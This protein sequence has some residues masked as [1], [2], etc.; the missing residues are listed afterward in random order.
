MGDRRA[1]TAI[2]AVE[3]LR[4]AGLPFMGTLVPLPH[5]S[6][7]DVEAALEYLDAHQA[8]TVRV[9]MPGLTRHHREYAPGVI[10]A[11]VP[12]VVE[13]VQALRERL[14]TPIIISP[15]AHVSTS[16]EAA[17]EGVIRCSPAATAGMRTGDRILALDGTE[18]V[19]RTHA[20]SLI[21]R[22]TAK[23]SVEVEFQRGNARMHAR[24]E[25]PPDEVD[26]YPYKPRDWHQ[27]N[28]SGLSFGLC[29]PGAFH[30]QYLRQIHDAVVGKGARHALVAASSFFRETVGLLLE[31]LPLPEGARLEVIVPRNEF[32]GGTVSVGD[33]WVLED[34]ER[35]VRPYLDAAERPDLL[36]LPDS[37]LSRWGRDLRGIP[38]TELEAHLGIDIALVACERIMM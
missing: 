4:D 15:F 37:F 18:V 14:E 31:Q 36:V 3:L 10:E 7:D 19:S 38:Y 1:E 23:G 5:Q 30:L 35:A 17:V 32:F 29:L 16:L 24:L 9:S 13:R 25:E 33:L 21:R 28:F 2:R 27:L 8:R 22:A 12:R 34:I 20:A 26:A 11:W 6:L